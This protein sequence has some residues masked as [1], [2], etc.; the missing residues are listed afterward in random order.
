[1][2]KSGK[3]ASGQEAF[4]RKVKETPV[5]QSP[6]VSTADMTSATVGTGAMV[7]STAKKTGTCT[8][9]PTEK[10]QGDLCMAEPRPTPDPQTTEAGGAHVEDDPHQCLYVGTPWEEEVITDRRDVDEFK[11][12][13]CTIGRVLSVRVLAWVLGILTLGRGI[14][15][16]LISVFAC[17]CCNL[18]LIRHRLG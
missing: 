6:M 10:R 13:S 12:A 9:P 11:E 5:E 2:S 14:M 15:Q 17:S 7:T 8:A 4:G 3:N 16:G 1:M 18:L